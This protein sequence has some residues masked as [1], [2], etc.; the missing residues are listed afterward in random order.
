MYPLIASYLE[1][2]GFRFLSSKGRYRK[3]IGDYEN[4]FSTQIPFEAIRYNKEQT[5]YVLWIELYSSIEIPCFHKWFAKNTQNE[6]RVATKTKRFEAYIELANNDLQEEDFFDPSEIRAFKHQ[7]FNELIGPRTESSDI[8]AINL[9]E[10]GKKVLLDEAD[11]LKN[12]SNLYSFLTA[13]KY[14]FFNRFGVRFL[15]PSPYLY[16]FTGDLEKA[17]SH[18]DKNYHEYIAMFPNVKKTHPHEIDSFLD[19]FVSFV[20][21]AKNL[22]D[23]DYSPDFAEL[24]NRIK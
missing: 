15:D 19:F 12:A 13:E 23:L 20:A 2:E 17:K 22:A 3:K 18:F 24:K 11:E 4:T 1:V 6:I 8:R 16:A 7:K 9:H 10:I 14:V 5:K 21:D